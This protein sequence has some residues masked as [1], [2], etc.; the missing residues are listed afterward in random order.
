MRKWWVWVPVFLLSIPS[1]L[2]ARTSSDSV[3]SIAVNDEIRALL[4]RDYQIDVLV[5]PHAGDAWTRLAKRVTGDAARWE[6]LAQFNHSDDNLKTEQAVRVPFALLRPSLQRDILRT[7]FPNDRRTDAGWMHIVV[8]G[9]GIEGEPLWNIAEWFSG[10]GANYAA[11]RKANPGQGLSTR[12]GD[13]IL[14]PNALLTA[15]FGSGPEGENAPKTAAEVRRSKDAQAQHAPADEDASE[16]SLPAPVGVPSLT[17]ER[18]NTEPYAVYRLQKGEALYS[19]VAI[20]FTGR[21]YAKDVGDVVERVVKFNNIEDVAKIPV[22]YAVRIPMDLLLPQYRPQDDPARLAEEASQRASAKLARRTRARNL[23]G[24]HVIL[25][26]GHG[27]SDPGATLGDVRESKYVYDVMC[28]LQHILEKKSAAMVSITR[29]EEA[30]LTT[31]EYPLDDA[32]VGVNLRWYLANS[33]FRRAIKAGVDKEKV[34]FISIHADSLHPSIRGAMAYIPGERFVRGS[35]E[36]RGSVYLARAEV[37]ERPVVR[38]S[39][40]E[41]LEAEGLSRD[42]GESVIAAFEDAHLPVHTF[43]PVRDNVVRD[44]SEWVPAVIRYN[45]VPTRLLLE[46]CNLGNRHDRELFMT[47]KF[48]QQVAEAIYRGLVDFYTEDADATQVAGRS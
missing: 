10:D 44:G 29:N 14:V 48:R 45:L 5:E 31:P 6:D 40:H 30:V 42:F 43:N 24:V 47:R 15:A 1:L 11:V 33:L 21:V 37:R 35:Y 17:Y 39:E 34:V 19:S 46:V 26:A 41:S 28:R 27:G 22:G 20:R 12:T 8:G 7:L 18:T 16:A 3:A 32:I 38:H 23:A 36:K 2:D 13:V 4:T 9:H 25:D